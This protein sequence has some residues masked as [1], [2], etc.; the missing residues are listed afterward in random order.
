LRVL[1]SGS[2]DTVAQATA[3]L[4]PAGAVEIKRKI[5]APRAPPPLPPNRIT[6]L[7]RI[8]AALA[9]M[10]ECPLIIDQTASYIVIRL[11]DVVMFDPGEAIL[12]PKFKPVAARIAE[13][14]DKEPGKVRVVGHTDGI[15]IKT[16][17]FPSN[18]HLSVE[19]AKVVAAVLKQGM[20]QAERVEIAGKGPDVPIATNDTPEGRAKNRRVEVMLARSE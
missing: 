3:T 11:C 9:D 15:P 13:V 20:S 16:V 12:L 18:W 19:R 17:R 7:K 5:I 8:R 10:G 14:I 4:H 1:L 2:S 6:Q